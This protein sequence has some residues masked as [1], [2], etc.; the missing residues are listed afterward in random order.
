MDHLKASQKLTLIRQFPVDVK[1]EDMQL[2][3]AVKYSQG[4]MAATIQFELRCTNFPV[5]TMVNVTCNA[6]GPTP[7]IYIPRMYVSASPVYT[8]G[9]VTRVPANFESTIE[10]YAYFRQVPSANASL[11][12]DCYL[13]E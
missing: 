6:P 1:I 5:G 9:I 12:L 10:I 13:V 8:T 11:S 2:R 3:T 7:P 4:D